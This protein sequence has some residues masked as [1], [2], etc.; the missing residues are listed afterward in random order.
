M[1]GTDGLE[2][3]ATAADDRLLPELDAAL[4]VTVLPVVLEN[5]DVLCVNKV[6]SV[7]EL[8][9]I[10]ELPPVCD[11]V[12]IVISVDSIPGDDIEFPAVGTLVELAR[13]RGSTD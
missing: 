2:I 4:L 6:Q 3:A 13:V 11:E 1:A 9:T 7:V 12:I 10:V 5:V 8:D